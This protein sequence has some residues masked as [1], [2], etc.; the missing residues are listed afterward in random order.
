MMGENGT[1]KTTFCK[2]LAGAIAPDGGRNTKIERLNETTKIAPKFTGTVRQL[3][4]KN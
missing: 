3:F 4:L 2:L 1:G